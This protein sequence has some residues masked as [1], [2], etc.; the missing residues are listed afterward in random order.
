MDKIESLYSK[1]WDLLGFLILIFLVSI[2]WK[3]LEITQL[4]KER[5]LLT[6]ELLRLQIETTQQQKERE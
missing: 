1:L 6:N 3:Q 5:L 4:S 2:L